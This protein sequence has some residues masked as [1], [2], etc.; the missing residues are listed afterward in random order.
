MMQA[1]EQHSPMTELLEQLERVMSGLG[2][3]PDQDAAAVAAR[4]AIEDAMRRIDMVRQL[5]AEP[6]PDI[7][8]TGLTMKDIDDLRHRMTMAA[9]VSMG[10]F[11]DKDTRISS[12]LPS[13]LVEEAMAKSG[14]TNMTALVEYALARVATE[15]D[16]GERLLKREGSVDK[17]LNL[18]F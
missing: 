2:A 9:G 7:L 1:S 18:E 4:R 8:G 6:L 16:F 10:L 14:I 3:C 15:D 13:R 17:R 11:S 12:R 5:T